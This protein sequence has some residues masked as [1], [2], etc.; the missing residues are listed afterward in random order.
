MEY[1]Y[2]FRIYPT[3]EQQVLIAKTLGCCRFV[4]N[5]YLNV[6]SAAW[7][8]QQKA[9]GYYE[10]SADMTKLKKTLLWLKEVDATA[11]QS[12]IRDLDTAYG[13]FFRGCKSGKH[14]GYPRFRSKRDTR[15]SFKSKAVG[16]NIVV[17]DS[18]IRLPKLGNVSCRVSKKVVGRILSVTTTRAPS[19]RYYV[20]ICC[21]DVD[22]LPLP[23]T[24]AVVGVD[25][26]TKNLLVTSD[27]FR[28][29]N[30]KST[31]KAERRLRRLQRSLSRK[32][33]GSKNRDK[34]RQKVARLHERIH[35]QR[36]AAIHEMTTDLVK[37]YDV[38]C[39]EDLNAAGM[40]R[41]H[42]LAKTVE[43]AAFGEIRRQLVYKAGWYGKKVIFVDR[44][45]PSSQLCSCCGYQ[46][47]L[48]KDL[49]VKGWMCPQCGVTHD[50]DV[51][52][53]RNILTEGLRK[54]SVA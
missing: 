33:K 40:V 21:T 15:Q 7:K 28:Y 12:S 20:S 2:R 47:R 52:A 6:R 37:K 16:K 49:G 44:F 14:I 30:S 39:M 11:L 13:N 54:A 3:D 32:Q 25:L 38:I 46:N 45:Y 17:G 35:D 27:G 18:F 10:C 29:K 1:S 36:E 22:L 23:K 24:G 41:N 31:Y 51:N 43:D 48:V 42:H 19:G 34:A 4:Y 50:R 53:A 26:D 5:Y 8:T 9:M